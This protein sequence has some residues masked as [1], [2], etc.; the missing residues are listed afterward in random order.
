[1]LQRVLQGAGHHL[2]GPDQRPHLRKAD[3]PSPLRIVL[4]LVPWL[5]LLQLLSC[6]VLALSI[7]LLVDTPSFASLL[8]TEASEIHLYSTTCYL[9]MVLSILV[10]IVTFL[11]CCGVAK[12]NRC[13]MIS[14]RL[15][16]RLLIASPFLGLA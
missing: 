7:W 14:V 3:L 15:P 5:V 9:V 13:M 4:K 10:A 16:R 6:A 11:G 2:R 12:E 1:M 8:E